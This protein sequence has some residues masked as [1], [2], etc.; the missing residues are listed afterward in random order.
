M[1]ATGR[2]MVVAGE[3][4]GDAI[5]AGLIREV[6]RR[7]SDLAFEGVGGAGMA[8]AG[9]RILADADRLAVVGLTEVLRHFPDIRRVFH[10]LRDRL[11]SDP[12][13]L[14]VCVDLPDFN[15]RLAREAQRAGVPV[16][17]YVSPQVWA[18]RRG[19]VRTIRRLVDHMLVLF[20][21]EAD[22]YR[23]AGVP[24]TWVGHPIVERIPHPPERAEARARLGVAGE[25]PVV[26]LMPGSRRSEVRRLGPVLLGAARRLR[27]RRPD[28]RFVLP[29]AGPEVGELLNAQEAEEPVPGL[30][31]VDDGVTAAAAAD[32]AAVASGTAT[33][34]TALVGTPHVIVYRLSP[35]TFWLARRLVR[36]PFVGIVNLIAG[37]EVAT[38]LLQDDARPERIA[39]ELA[40]LLEDPERRRAAEAA[41][42]EVRAALGEAPS[43]RA[44][45]VVLS[46]AGAA[47]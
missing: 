24:V 16:V 22:L 6:G 3:A 35:V 12:P 17:Y 14:L 20:P 25:G 41:M 43:A 37:R 33:L 4:S 47:P 2:I 36:V 46:Q 23:E 29:V 13:R 5:A 32:C 8:D 31:R 26:A 19:R 27:E 9:C 30:M 34:E 39:A 18:W 42:A 44:A 10:L 38:E 40:G 45:D 15:L 1:S 11:R 28:I 7:R 21:F